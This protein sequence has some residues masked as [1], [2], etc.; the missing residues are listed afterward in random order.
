[1][2][3]PMVP[4]T[5]EEIE[6]A[7]A[8]ASAQ[9]HGAMFTYCKLLDPPKADVAAWAPG[10][11]ALPRV[12]RLVGQ[13]DTEDGGFEAD[14]TLGAGADF[15]DITRIDASGGSAYG[16]KDFGTAM[17]ILFG[18]ADWIAALAKRGIKADP[19][20]I[21][22]DPWPAGGF[23]HKNIPAGHRSMRAICFE[24]AD[25]G[26]NGYAKPISGVLA[27]IDITAKTVVE[28]EDHGVISVPQGREGDRYDGDNGHL[29]E[30]R[31]DLKPIEISQPEGVSFTI[32]EGNRIQWLG[33]DLRALIDPTHALELRQVSLHGR[34]LLYRM[35]LADMVVPYGDSDPMHSWKHV[36]DATEFGMGTMVG[37]LELGCDCLGD[38]HYLDSAQV[39][40][41]GDAIAK[42]NGKCSSS[43]LLSS[44]LSSP[45]DAK[46][47]CLRR[48]RSLKMLLR[49]YLHPRGGREHRLA[50]PRRPWWWQLRAP[51]PAAGRQ[52][53]V[54]R[55]KLRL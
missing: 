28:V 11:A 30:P 54:Y 13:D 44:L 1:M 39:L 33:W 19:E 10:S 48:R 55:R 6:R 3:H 37:S 43:P 26:D 4:L 24:K 16:A 53:L 15:V 42:K 51:Q 17:M 21:Q 18:D 7:T 38:I 35:S 32:T 9:L 41:T 45:Q 36:L 14:V 31:T 2:A 12:V 23:A 52:Q 20:K 8:A 34:P 47:S 25:Q 29:P 46:A 27:H 50:P 40:P 5:T 49:S 22:V